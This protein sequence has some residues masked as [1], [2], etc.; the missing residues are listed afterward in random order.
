MTSATEFKLKKTEESIHKLQRQLKQKTCPKSLQYKA[1]VNIAPN[2]IFWKEIGAIKKRTEQDHVSTLKHFHHRQ[3]ERHTEKITQAKNICSS[4]RIGRCS[5]KPQQMTVKFTSHNIKVR[6]LK[7]WKDLKAKGSHIHLNEDITKTRLAIL[8][9]LNE[10][11]KHLIY[12]TWTIDGII[13]ARLQKQN[14]K[15]LSFSTMRECSKF[16]LNSA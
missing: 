3:L 15:V 9:L 11:G 12:E 7:K 14:N 2:N 5:N 4:H 10:Q 13:F 1:Q 6:T 8:H 16:L